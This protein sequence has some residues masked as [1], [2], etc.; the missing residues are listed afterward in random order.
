MHAPPQHCPLLGADP[1]S[2]SVLHCCAVEQDSR[3]NVSATI[4]MAPDTQSTLLSVNLHPEH[5]EA[6]A[7]LP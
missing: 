2:L 5:V 7:N 6:V 3:Q 1:Q 4:R